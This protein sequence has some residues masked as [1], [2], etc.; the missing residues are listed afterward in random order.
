MR[1]R[2]GFQSQFYG[3]FFFF[4]IQTTLAGLYEI[5][6]SSPVTAIKRIDEVNLEAPLMYDCTTPQ[7]LVLK[8]MC[9]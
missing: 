4:N 7:H 6:K 8:D 2:Y 3:E 1:K 9:P 5:T